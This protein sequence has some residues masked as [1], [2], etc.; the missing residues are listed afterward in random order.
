MMTNYGRR[1]DDMPLEDLEPALASTLTDSQKINIKII[2]NL[3]SL[4]TALNDTQHDV[5]ILNKLVIT[6][7]GDPALVEK[8]RNLEQFVNNTKYW[9]RLVAGA[10]VLQTI[11]FGSAAIIYFVKL[12]PILDRLAKTP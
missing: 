6:G 4:N 7:N 12:S 10:M 5:S 9:L 11:T 8:V 2:Q 3:T 1:T